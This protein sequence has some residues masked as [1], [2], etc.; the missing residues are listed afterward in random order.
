MN[1][2]CKLNFTYEY[3]TTNEIRGAQG[4]ATQNPPRIEKS[5]KTPPP[6]ESKNQAKPPPRIE[7]EDPPPLSRRA[8]RGKTWTKLMKMS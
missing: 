8:K 7:I 5:G 4:G 2:Y 3:K 1:S 6:L